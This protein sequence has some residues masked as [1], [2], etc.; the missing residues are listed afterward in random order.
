MNGRFKS[1]I[2]WPAFHY[3]IDGVGDA[4]EAVEFDWP[5]HL[6]DLGSEDFL[7]IGGMALNPRTGQIMR[8]IGGRGR[9]LRVEFV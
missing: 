4:V 3:A 7:V 9:F 1:P 8:R 2:A 6:I 5:G